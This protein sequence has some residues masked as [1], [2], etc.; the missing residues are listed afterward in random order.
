MRAVAVAA[1][2]R[3]SRSARSS[4][5][6]AL[7]VDRHDVVGPA[8]PH[9]RDGRVEERGDERGRRRPQ[10][11]ERRAH[12]VELGAGLGARG[13]RRPSAAG[14]Q[15]R[16]RGA[17]LELEA[18]VQRGEPER[19]LVH[20]GRAAR[21]APAQVRLGHARGHRGRDGALDHG[22]AHDVGHGRSRPVERVED[23]DARG[24]QGARRVEDAL[25]GVRVGP[26]AHG[27]AHV[28]EVG[29][30]VRVR[31][32]AQG[33]REREPVG[34]LARV[35]LCPAHRERPQRAVGPRVL[36][37]EV[38]HGHVQRRRRGGGPVEPLDPPAVPQRLHSRH[39]RHAASVPPP[40]DRPRRQR[41]ARAAGP[42]HRGALPGPGGCAQV[43]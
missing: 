43:R 3:A 6:L 30:P 27:R 22:F 19:L 18:R 33:P 2:R 5:L 20:V 34:P 32:A 8:P 35:D 11:V 12:E 10:E 15:D 42:R 23:G 13:S 16:W 24:P 26:G 41:T 36:H 39:G 40:S 29:A 7:D 38:E 37:A 1:A 14:R 4:A 9:V 25:G 17:G 28:A 21:A 31:C